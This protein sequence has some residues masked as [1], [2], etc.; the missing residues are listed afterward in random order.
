MEIIEPGQVFREGDPAECLYVL[1][2][3]TVVLSRKVG[4]DDV[5]ISR[6]SQRG[7]YAGS[8]QAYLGDR[9][10]Q[11][12]PNSLRVTE[13]ST[14]YVLG[15]AVLR[16]DHERVVPD[17][18]APARGAVL[19][20][21]ADPRGGRPAGAAAR[22][23]LADRGPDPRAQ[24]P[25]RRGGAGDRQPARAG[26]RDARQAADDGGGQVR[27]RQPGIDHRAAAA[28]GGEG[29]QGAEAQ[30]A[31]DV[32]RGRRAQRLAGGPR[33]AT[34]AGSSPRRSSRPGLDAEWLD[35][36]RD[37]RRRR[38]CSNPRCAG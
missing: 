13:P 2:E 33:H 3:G 22:A 38:A 25:R 15:A 31:R 28:R 16:A 12:Y 37:T 29:L 8:F 5:E 6:T 18:G 34:T 35:E 7:V 14:F 23:R 36:V 30:P 26:R 10:P 21:S 24:Q 32:R 20:R 1:I 9:V 27:A 4:E 19:R 11:V 17:G